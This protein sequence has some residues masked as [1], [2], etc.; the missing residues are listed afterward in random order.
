M[1]TPEV[2]IDPD[3]SMEEVAQKF[4]KSG[5]F[6]LVVLKGG[7]YLGFISRANVFSSYRNLLRKFSDD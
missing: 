3:E 6:N 2:T 7:K 5:K 1:F 4:Q